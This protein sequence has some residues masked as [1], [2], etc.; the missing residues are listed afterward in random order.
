[1]PAAACRVLDRIVATGTVETAEGE[2]LP[3]H[4]NISGAEGAFLQR[5]IRQVRPRRSIEVGF[6]YGVS[7]LYICEALVEVGADRHLAIDPY[8]F[9]VPASEQVCF[10]GFTGWRGV[11]VENVRRAGYAQLVEHVAERSE[12]ALPRMAGEGGRFEFAFIDGY[13][14]FEAAF[15]DFFFIDR[16]VPVGGVIA[17]DDL[18]Y[19]AVKKLVRFV[20][21]NRD[22]SPILTTREPPT[23]SWKRR[24]VEP[25]LRSRLKPE[26]IIPDG[27]LGIESDWI[28]LRK[29]SALPNGDVPGA[30]RW[31]AHVDF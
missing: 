29:N 27:D 12:V 23:K 18:S 7:T 9:N 8:Q 30:R 20:I 10:S 15:V 25:L 14:T 19:P 17:F 5:V 13:H 26:I 24:L 21:L 22:Y 28:A 16:M 3:V 4:S 11:G 1:M 6:A 2:T 31:D